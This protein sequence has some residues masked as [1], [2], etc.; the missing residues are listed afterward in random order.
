[1]K[2]VLMGNMAV[3]DDEACFSVGGA[4]CR[5]KNILIFENA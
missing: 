2:Y 1:M 3:R 4:T 5:K